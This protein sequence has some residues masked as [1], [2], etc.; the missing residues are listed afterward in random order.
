[1][2]GILDFCITCVTHDLGQIIDMADL[3]GSTPNPF[4][5]VSCPPHV[6]IASVFVSDA[7]LPTICFFLTPNLYMLQPHHGEPLKK[8]LLTVR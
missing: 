5:P 1:M 6:F 8:R 7:S 3:S 2:A 4:I